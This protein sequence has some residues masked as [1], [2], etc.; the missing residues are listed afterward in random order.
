MPDGTY[1]PKVYR[2]QGGDELVVASGGKITVESGGL[3]TGDGFVVGA[4]DDVTIE[5]NVS[6]E[7]AVKDGGIDTAQLADEGVL[8]A[9]LGVGLLHVSLVDGQDE[10]SGPDL[11][12]ALT[13]IEVGDEIVSVILNSTKASIATREVLT[14][15]TVT[16]ADEISSGSAVDRSN[17]QLEV[18]WIDRTP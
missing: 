8:G 4:V 1:Q 3:I 9:K 16:G 10:T 17:D 13:G 18:M 14:G 7:I 11:T 6:D 5:V 2:K 12:Y 15:F